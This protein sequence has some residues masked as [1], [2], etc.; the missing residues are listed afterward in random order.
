MRDVTM[1]LSKFPD[2]RFSPQDPSVSNKKN[3]LY[4]QFRMTISF[5]VLPSP[6]EDDKVRLLSQLFWLAIRLGIAV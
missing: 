3:A 2:A 5:D 4:C 1:L 6:I